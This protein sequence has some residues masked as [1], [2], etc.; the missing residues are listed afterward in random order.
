MAPRSP[1]PRSDKN[2]GGVNTHIPPATL[3]ER[4]TNVYNTALNP[5]PIIIHVNWKL[6]TYRIGQI[7]CDDY[8]RQVYLQVLAAQNEVIARDFEPRFYTCINTNRPGD[9][10]LKLSTF[11]PADSVRLLGCYAALTCLECWFEIHYRENPYRN[12]SR[13]ELA[14]I[15]FSFGGKRDKVPFPQLFTNAWKDA[16]V[17]L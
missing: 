7:D 12:K 4:S 8:S 10:P 3:P 13:Q 16:K 9:E 11:S 2:S 6:A 1:L 14:T 5:E 17:T 15:L